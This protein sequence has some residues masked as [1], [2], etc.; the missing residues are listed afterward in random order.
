MKP[1]YEELKEID[2]WK[3]CW[4]GERNSALQVDIDL[5]S[6]MKCKK[7][8]KQNRIYASVEYMTHPCDDDGEEL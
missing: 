8:G 6:T 4:C 1:K 2:D 7:C 3:C 5:G